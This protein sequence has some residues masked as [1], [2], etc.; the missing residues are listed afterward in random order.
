MSHMNIKQRARL[1][2][3]VKG[4]MQLI[5]NVLYLLDTYT[6]AYEPISFHYERDAV[7]A[8]VLQESRLMSDILRSFRGERPK[9][10]PQDSSLDLITKVPVVEKN[11]NDFIALFLGS[12]RLTA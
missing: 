5:A 1:E 2:I 10:S 6:D 9:H 11:T 7:R 12:V 4:R 8:A 3:H